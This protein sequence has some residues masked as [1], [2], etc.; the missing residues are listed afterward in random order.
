MKEL[1]IGVFF[2]GTGNN[3]QNALSR[4][5]AGD[6]SV[7][8]S[9]NQSPTN[10]Y[11]LYR[12]Y[13][14]NAAEDIKGIYIEG[15]GTLNFHGDSIASQATGNDIW[16]G[17]SATA[18]NQKAFEMICNLLEEFTIKN[19]NKKI[20]VKLT[21]DLFGFSRGAALARNFSNYIIGKEKE[22][23]QILKSESNSLD[24]LNIGFIG[25]FDTVSKIAIDNLN[26][27]LN[28]DKVKPKAVFHITAM[29]ECRAHFPLTSIRSRS[30]NYINCDSKGSFAHPSKDF[31]EMIVPGAHSDIGGGYNFSQ[32]EIATINIHATWTEQGAK[33]DT[34]KICKS[35][36][37]FTPL[38]EGLNYEYEFI[39][40]RGY[41]TI[42]RRKAVKGHIQLLY[43]KLMIE[44]AVKYGVPFSIPKFESNY[45][46]PEDL[47]SYYEKLNNKKKYPYGKKEFPA[48][49][50]YNR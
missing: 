18:K 22:L 36:P 48:N 10:I 23:K 46:I 4:S 28:L 16:E 42:S 12:N 41:N 37:D 2:D 20:N 50:H 49:K 11:R 17:Y 5:V 3:A 47:I 9:Y 31:F 6:H 26:L 29:H 21:I 43:A 24:S 40:S 8:D 7:G 30:I 1:R 34:Q 13:V 39:N 35:N 14:L 27:N 25:L 44:A 33:D 15:I 45:T 38:L 19:S 32:D